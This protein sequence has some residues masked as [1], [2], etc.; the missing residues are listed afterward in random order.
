M[1]GKHNEDEIEQQP[2]NIPQNK[3]GESENSSMWKTNRAQHRNVAQRMEGN[4]SELLFAIK[5][6]TKNRNSVKQEVGIVLL[7]MMN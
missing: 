6:I 2:V 7:T 3:L 1:S 4:S 5:Q